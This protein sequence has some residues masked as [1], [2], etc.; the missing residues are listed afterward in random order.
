LFPVRERIEKEKEE[1]AIEDEERAA[2]HYCPRAAHGLAY[3]LLRLR[4][5]AT[6]S[7]SRAPAASHRMA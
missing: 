7:T 4:R 6:K 2:G 1:D 3:M 5:R